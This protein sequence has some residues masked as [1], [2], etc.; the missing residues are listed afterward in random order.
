MTDIPYAIEDARLLA[1]FGYNLSEQERELGKG[2]MDDIDY[3][4]LFTLFPVGIVRRYADRY[5][6]A[7]GGFYQ[8]GAVYSEET[9]HKFWV[10]LA[11]GLG[12]NYGDALLVGLPF[13]PGPVAAQGRIAVR[14][15]DDLRFQ[16][17]ILG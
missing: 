15:G 4:E 2:L 13:P 5:P 17:N 7:F 1:D 6:G 12:G 9:L 8:R 16:G 11:A 3:L 14:D 10:K